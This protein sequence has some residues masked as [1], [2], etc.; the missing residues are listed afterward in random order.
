MQFLRKSRSFSHKLKK[1]HFFGYAR[2]ASLL[3]Y[4][5]PSLSTLLM[6]IQLSALTVNCKLMTVSALY[7]QARVVLSL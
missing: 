1:K 6:Q 4:S 2:P 7:I 3:Q 5:A